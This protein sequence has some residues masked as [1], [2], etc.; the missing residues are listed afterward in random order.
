MPRLTSDEYNK[1]LS[2]LPNAPAPGIKNTQPFE[3]WVSNTKNNINNQLQ[4][5]QLAGDDSTK[6]LKK[7]QDDLW[8]MWETNENLLPKAASSEASAGPLDISSNLSAVVG[9]APF[10]DITTI[11]NAKQ[12]VINQL[13]TQHDVYITDF[14]RTFQ[15]RTMVEVLERDNS[16]DFDTFIKRFDSLADLKDSDIQMLKTAFEKKQ[17]Q[18]PPPKDN[19]QHLDAQTERG[20]VKALTVVPKDF[21][22]PEGVSPEGI[23]DIFNYDV[24]EFKTKSDA[25]LIKRVEGMRMTVAA[26]KAGTTGTG[27]IK[28]LNL[29][30]IAHMVLAQPFL[31]CLDLA[32]YINDNFDIPISGAIVTGIGGKIQTFTERKDW[33]NTTFGKNYWKARENGVD[34]WH[35]FGA[36][37][38]DDVSWFKPYDTVASTAKENLDKTMFIDPVTGESIPQ[39]PGTQISSLDGIAKLA[40]NILLTPGIVVGWAGTSK[41]T[42]KIPVVGRYIAGLN[43]GWIAVTEEIA[44]IV[45]FWKF[46]KKI[47]ETPIQ[48]I[49]RIV[50]E[51]K[52]N[53]FAALSQ[54]I[55]RDPAKWT[56]PKMKAAAKQAV[57][58]A[59][60]HPELLG[61]SDF[62]NWG[63]WMLTHKAMTVDELEFVTKRL[64]MTDKPTI[65]QLSDVFQAF[66]QMKFDGRGIGYTKAETID[67]V[68]NSLGIRSTEDSR[69]VVEE[70]LVNRQK[71]DLE[72]VMEMFEGNNP[73]KML[74]AVTAR[75]RDTLLDNHNSDVAQF[76]AKGNLMAAILKGVDDITTKGVVAA[77]DKN[78]TVPM[79]KQMLVFPNFGPWNNLETIIRAANAGYNVIP[80]MMERGNST[81]HVLKLITSDLANCPAWVTDGE[82]RLLIA[83]GEASKSAYKAT[84][85]GL[86]AIERFFKM[87]PGIGKDLPFFK[88]K[89]SLKAFASWQSLNDRQAAVGMKG[90]ASY[91]YQSYTQELKEIIPD[92]MKE[93]EKWSGS[94][95]EYG[96]KRF[97]SQQLNEYINLGTHYA[98]MGADALNQLRHTT[99]SLTKAWVGMGVDDILKSHP[100]LPAEVGDYLK[101]TA[102]NKNGLD[103]IPSMV[104]T[105]KGQIKDSELIRATQA[106]QIYQQIADGLKNVPIQT[107]DGLDDMMRVLSHASSEVGENIGNFR[108]MATRRA[109]DFF[110]DTKNTIHDESWKGLDTYMSKTN[111]ALKSIIDD[112]KAKMGTLA[113]DKLVT[114][115]SMMDNIIKQTENTV[116]Y[117]TKQASEFAALVNKYGG[118][119]K[120]R[121]EGNGANA[122]KFWEANKL[123]GNKLYDEFRAK[124]VL[125]QKAADDLQLNL[126][127]SAQNPLPK[128][129][130]DLLVAHIAYMFNRTSDNLVESLL[131]GES[132]LLTAKDEFIDMV[133]NRAS[134]IA[135]KAKTTA[136]NAGFSREAIG[137]CYDAVK[138]SMGLDPAVDSVLGPKLQAIN[139]IEWNLNN[140]KA[141]GMPDA[142]DVAAFNKWIDD[143]ISQFGQS[144]QFLND[145]R[146]KAMDAARISYAKDFPDYTVQNAATA[147][148]KKAFPFFTYESQ[149]W[150]YILRNLVSKPALITAYGHFRDNTDNGYLPIIGTDDYQVNLAGGTVWS[151]GYNRLVQKDFPEYNDRNPALAKVV[152]EMNRRGFYPGAWYGAL[153]TFFGADP[154]KRPE[155]GEL[156]PPWAEFGFDILAAVMP[157]NPYVVGVRD[158]LLPDGFRTYFNAEWLAVHGYDAK[159]IA[160]K[161][162]IGQ[163][164]DEEEQKQ[165]N[166]ASQATSWLAAAN[167]VGGG[168]LKYKPK[169][170]ADARYAAQKLIELRK[171][172]TPE[173]QDWINLHSGITG[174]DLAYYIELDPLDNKVIDEAT[175]VRDF[176][177]LITSL[178]PSSQQYARSLLTLYYHAT[179]DVR[180]EATDR[181][182]DNIPSYKSQDSGFI[183]WCRDTTGKLGMSGGD[184]DKNYSNLTDVVYKRIDGLQGDD[185]YKNLPITPDK[186]EKY[187]KENGV[188]ITLGPMEELL[189]MYHSITPKTDPITKI[190]DYDTFYK[191]REAI[192]D[193]VAPEDQ[194]RFIQNI[195]MWLTPIA[196][197]H[198]ASDRE[199]MRPYYNIGDK[200]MELYT[201]EEQQKIKEVKAKTHEQRLADAEAKTKE[202]NLIS[203]TVKGITTESEDSTRKLKLKQD[204]KV[205]KM[206]EELDALKSDKQ[207][208]VA[209][210][211]ANDKGVIRE[212][213]DEKIRVLTA[214]ISYT[215]QENKDNI[216]A[217]NTELANTIDST[218]SKL[219]AGLPDDVQK[220]NKMQRDIE[221]KNKE[222]AKKIS[223]V[224]RPDAATMTSHTPDEIEKLSKDAQDERD[225]LAEE[226]DLE[227]DKMRQELTDLKGG[228]VSKYNKDVNHAQD[229][230]RAV[231]PM[232]DAWLLLWGKTTKPASDKGLELY[233]EIK[234]NIGKG[235]YS[236]YITAYIPPVRP[237]TE[238]LQK[239]K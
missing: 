85:D 135:G 129:D 32:I 237:K 179:D 53:M 142:E 220:V 2:T 114:Y 19:S 214:D 55:D 102:V 69:L 199:Y 201:T 138:H 123:L 224:K 25:D 208:K 57:D 173:Q 141:A 213:Y 95:R 59:I 42:G 83:A 118:W 47:P 223:A 106:Y 96:I 204:T 64:G 160:A 71:T 154:M 101:D 150:P 228:V 181:G 140:M 159:V 200:V 45:T 190:T 11:F 216:T 18:A 178:L 90:V 97:D 134:N 94:L 62:M 63:R 76:L 230:L 203:T 221:A 37:Y 23:L 113:G 41:W 151:G 110:G 7:A 82:V 156:V 100:N 74:K 36:V 231:D 21:K 5:L 103:D 239:P 109:E 51:A 31:A 40:A 79:A 232:L 108:S 172:L 1:A 75:I 144:T 73:T 38:N 205:A 127:P 26:I 46:F 234:D 14:N 139:N 193:A 72:Y 121:G 225:R 105:M 198:W 218:T 125:L 219:T 195:N 43:N 54:A 212:Q 235:D 93:A 157:D 27:S 86:P 48:H 107:A 233:Q 131:K 52:G 184:W 202:E 147:L 9:G 22:L 196:Q 168:I 29:W 238:P 80:G 177:G 191:K 4:L 169:K 39:K 98:T 162:N 148:L 8:R 99:D 164:L 124:R 17:Q 236:Q 77:I 174:K 34:Y 20:I 166:R 145:A 56:A 158:Y 163:K 211:A 189:Q 165:W 111:A 33:S 120:I 84:L 10:G 115:T 6:K 128:F 68:L 12:D 15:V 149:R 192:I 188:V 210:A 167:V 170:I 65:Q 197:I 28:N 58:D 66:E 78:F 87:I 206:R 222:W 146:K 183:D 16:P 143:G 136:E 61:T 187:H 182:L 152:S 13:I 175:G 104:N 176:T 153:M 60:D 44:D 227:M 116:A 81:L 88:D 70:F 194:P 130:G 207:Y 209:S 186:K 126:N 30:E 91:F 229:N 50:T 49:D 92:Y 217:A 180:T 185:R 89:E 215:V 117:R 119:K 35:A 161:M 137:K 132:G 122:D 67:R 226:R 171:G 133:Y 112:T 24:D 3:T 155:I